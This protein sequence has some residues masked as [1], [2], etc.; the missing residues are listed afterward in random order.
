MPLKPGAVP[1][2]APVE[3]EHTLE[4]IGVLQKMRGAASPTKPTSTQAATLVRMEAGV[5]A[6]GDAAVGAAILLVLCNVMPPTAKITP[7]DIAANI[8]KISPMLISS[9]FLL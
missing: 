5:R 9:P 2:I 4:P 1:R 6:G 3:D 8:T 7:N